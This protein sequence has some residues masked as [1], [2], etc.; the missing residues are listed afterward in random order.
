M[1]RAGL[2]K[3][4][5][6]NSYSK[7][8][9]S[10]SERIRKAVTSQEIPFEGVYG[11][12]DVKENL[13]NALEQASFVSRQGYIPILLL[14]GP[15][16]SGKTELINS[17]IRSYKAYTRDNE[18]FTLE[19]DGKVCPYNEN[20]YNIY[21]TI[22]PKE[23]KLPNKEIVENLLMHKKRP[24][25]CMQCEH[26]LEEL[27]NKQ[28]N[29][30][31]DEPKISLH[32]IFP[33]SSIVEFG[34][35]FLLPTFINIIRNSNRSVLT[36]SA[37]KNRLDQINP[38]VFQL[39]NNVYDNN[40]SDSTG[41]RIPLDSL[42]IIHS[43]EG[44]MEIP[45][46][47]K[48]E[49]MPLLER[50]IKVNVRRNLSYSEEMKIIDD[51]KLPIKKSVPKFFEYISKIN[52]LSRLSLDSIDGLDDNDLE[53]VINLLD[54]YDSSRLGEFEKNMTQST[55]NFLYTLNDN[56]MYNSEKDLAEKR[57]L[58]E[59][60]KSLILY[61]SKYKSGW[62][63]GISSRAIS[64]IIDFNYRSKNLKGYLSF[65]DVRSYLQ[66]NESK[67]E[68]ALYDIIENYI[69]KEVTKNVTADIDYAIL[70]FYFGDHF[71]DYSNVI[72]SYFNS[73]IN[74]GKD[75]DF[76]DVNGYLAEASR[77]FDVESLKNEAQEFIETKVPLGIVNYSA[78]FRSIF[79][80]LVSTGK[81][82]IKKESNYKNFIGE[83]GKDVDKKSKLY[84]Y[85]KDYLKNNLGY[86][87]EAVEEAFKIYKEG[88]LMYD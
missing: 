8:E 80:F 32:R 71:K 4:I 77:Y 17:I 55:S 13:M 9:E 61:E 31:S 14:I 82:F 33:Q 36:I 62:S 54:Y 24:E 73:L 50:I 68:S 76:K 12:R 7:N 26:N 37:D 15:S 52:V 19:I 6:A 64:N 84:P 48:N 10:T 21:R 85:I 41:N 78:D 59:A 86:F 40:L 67:I 44:F 49:S 5:Q 47:E 38:K 18:I 46:D 45:E 69:D 53:S 25:L 65:S 70:S 1:V 22:L 81:E 42:I 83:S 63:Y 34:D 11:I 79:N 57:Y 60:A 35:S 74:I 72:A 39:M 20:P 27:L 88:T 58:E 29:E 51:Y 2:E 75:Q 3:L 87:D 66:K 28:K 23:V 56:R 16:G 30:P 43:N